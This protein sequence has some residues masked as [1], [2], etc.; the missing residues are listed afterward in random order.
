MTTIG[1]RHAN[2]AHE[3]LQRGLPERR[4]L[5]ELHGVRG[6]ALL[7]VVLFHLF[8]NGR[9]SGGI[10]IF[11]AV[12]GFLFTGMLLREA[13]TR[14]GRVDPLKYYGRLVRR[15]LIPAALVVG[16]TLVIGL[17][18]SP[19]TK[20]SQLWAEARASLLYFENF[21]L[22]NSQLAYG[23]A[24]PET[25]PFQHFWSL[26]VQGQFYIF[27][28][29]IAILAVFLAKRLRRSAASVM[30]ALIGIVFVT[31]FIYA[32]YVGSY[33]QDEA[34]L[35]TTTRAW[36]L[37]F[38]G[39][40]A[41]VGGSIR[42][43]RRFRAPAGWLGLALIISAGFLLD[44]AQ[45]FPGPWALWPL[46]GLTL[47][48]ISAGPHGGDKDPRTTATRFLSNKPLAW[49]G[50]HAYG[51][52]L[53]H[54]PILIYYLEFREREAIGIRGGLAILALTVVLAML[55]YRYVEVPLK[56]R[57][58]LRAANIA[59]K[60]DKYVVTITAGVL[61]LAST[62][63]TMALQQPQHQT[64]EVF[65]DWDWE[66]YPGAMVTTPEYENAPP[67][68]GFLPE[69]QQ[70]PQERAVL[71]DRDERC[72][73]RSGNNPDTNAVLVCDDPHVSGD[74]TARVVI[75]GGSHSVHWHAAFE[76]LA[77]EYNWELL[78]VNKDA[79]VFKDTSEAGTD[80]CAAWNANYIEWLKNNDVDL[81]IANGTRIS[82]KRFEFIQ[83]GAQ[84][85]WQ[86]I[87]ESG[88]ELL[89]MRG[90]PRPGEN[91][92][93]CLADG[94]QPNQCGSDIN[95]IDDVNPLEDENL[96][97]G[98]HYLDMLEHVCPEGMTTSSEQCSAVVG[99]V[100]VWYDG[101][102]LTNQY[103]ATMTPIIETELRKK[104]S[105]LFEE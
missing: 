28:P 72:I 40:L 101:S 29:V 90:T 93:D 52:Y 6:L 65:E 14:N 86:E 78:V 71:Y 5:P 55:T 95:N 35:M 42:L 50:D 31:S 63:S 85:R 2:T 37:A 68:T 26:S 1:P 99:N 54:W 61:V 66:T 80:E 43:P 11:L 62:G 13:T 76:A 100:V 70:L 83:E 39:L 30:A 12:S 34:Y 94:K 27:W 33:N 17:M 102:H 41:L 59:R 15:I 23:A 97:E 103:V 49:I 25:S 46:A 24:G 77:K 19:V 92:A 96:P 60:V 74:P 104:V 57:Q 44:G 56:N 105:W 51:L 36:Q 69:V 21:E 7:G 87:T 84:N 45:L 53:W 91:V 75:S 79:C 8:G 20:H 4:Y 38:G 3:K 58:Q 32:I 48:L 22:I 98:A 88:A 67:Q 64:A 47:V 10:D 89:L 73:Q 82:T 9:V 16:V 81:V 18:I